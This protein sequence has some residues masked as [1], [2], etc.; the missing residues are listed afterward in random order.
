MIF[1]AYHQS[2]YPS[3]A[4]TNKECI[5]ECALIKVIERLKSAIMN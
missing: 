4:P 5:V 3:A 2:D 1:T